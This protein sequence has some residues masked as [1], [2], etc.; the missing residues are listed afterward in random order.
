M[1]IAFPG[2][3]SA[4]NGQAGFS[5]DIADGLRELDVHLDEGLLHAQDVG[6]TMLDGLGA[7]AQQR[8]QCNQ[9]GF[10][11]EGIGQ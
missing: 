7:I 10:R 9:V 1:R 8:A 11:A 5:G 2:D 6:R 4:D 3:D